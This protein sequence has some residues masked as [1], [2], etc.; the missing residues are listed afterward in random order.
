MG[1]CQSSD[2][3]GGIGGSASFF[4]QN[5]RPNSYENLRVK[6]KHA[7]IESTKPYNFWVH[8]LDTQGNILNPGEK[9]K[10]QIPKGKEGVIVVQGLP[11][12]GKYYV[13][14][15]TGDRKEFQ[16]RKAVYVNDAATRSDKGEFAEL[17]YAPI[18]PNEWLKNSSQSLLSV[19]VSLNQS[20]KKSR[21]IWFRAVN[22]NGAKVAESKQVKAVV[23][24]GSCP[25]VELAAWI[26]PYAKEIQL[27]VRSGFGFGTPKPFRCFPVPD[28]GTT[29]HC[30][31][32]N[33][34]DGTPK[35][36]SQKQEPPNGLQG[37]CTKIT[38]DN[39]GFG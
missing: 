7:P 33:F 14:L 25:K 28:F 10:V 37:P 15:M 24:D 1:L 23:N 12:H 17:D 19:W 13:Q 20:E 26:S 18:I 30:D 29:S 16:V 3:D 36:L 35:N 9:R 5:K 39:L 32:F 2:D 27:F 38:I 6:L 31:G 34:D 8:V 21:T 11:S 22:E 4:S